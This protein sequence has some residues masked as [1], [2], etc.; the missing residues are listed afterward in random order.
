MDSRKPLAGEFTY[1][2]KTL[3]IVA[4][5]FNSKGGDTP[6]FGSV[7][8]PVRSSEDQRHQQAEL[9][10]SFAD[11]LLA[12]DPDARIVV[13]GDLNDFQFSETMR[14]LES[15]GSRTNLIS[16]LP[17]AEQ[18]TY[19]FDGNSQALDH[20]LLSPSLLARRNGQPA[21]A[22]DVVHVNSEFADQASDHDPQVVRLSLL[23]GP[24]RPPRAA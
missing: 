3:F 5:H 4:N 13:L 16:T 11:D 9:V 20:T 2:G 10:R 15:T 12:S 17:V 21:F 1:R 24:T 19:V 23:R 14:I 6:L 18:Y 8:P 7:Q 22:Y